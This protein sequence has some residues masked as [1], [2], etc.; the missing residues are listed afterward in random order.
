MR[1]K[2]QYKASVE[3]DLRR[4]ARAEAARILHTLSENLATDPRQG[5]PLKGKRKDALWR[6]RIG[7]YR[8]V[9]SF[10]DTELWILV[11]HRKEVYRT[12]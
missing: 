8:V 11:V 10:S 12:L 9:Y 7:D 6:Y 4:I 5:I 3:K 1:Y 2:I